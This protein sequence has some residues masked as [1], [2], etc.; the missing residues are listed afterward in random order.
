MFSGPPTASSMVMDKIKP[1]ANSWTA[2]YLKGL[3][4]AH[5]TY[6]IRQTIPSDPFHT[7]CF[8]DILI[9]PLELCLLKKEI[10][11][12]LWVSHEGCELHP[13]RLWVLKCDCFAAYPIV[14]PLP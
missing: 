13:I 4:L 2:V 12:S 1:C 3:N 9:S 5:T 6:A 7:N 11:L 10:L 8:D 14:Q